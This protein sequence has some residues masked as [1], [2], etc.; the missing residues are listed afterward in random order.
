MGYSTSNPPYLETQAVAGVRTWV[1]TTTD[2]KETVDTD[3]YFTNGKDLGF[4]V[5]DLIKVACSDDANTE[6]V[7]ATILTVAS[8]TCDIG[9]PTVI[10]STADAD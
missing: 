3:G 7:T 9:T 2:P 4:Q 6:W 8:T 5:G 1:Y 10:G